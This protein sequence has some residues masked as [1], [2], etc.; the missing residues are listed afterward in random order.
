LLIVVLGLATTV[1]VTWYLSRARAER[2]WRTAWNRH[3]EL[4]Q[5]KRT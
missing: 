2:L 1:G 3:A 5:A 4:E